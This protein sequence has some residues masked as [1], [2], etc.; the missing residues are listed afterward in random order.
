MQLE[1]LS[2]LYLNIT[3][4]ICYQ[5]NLGKVMLMLRALHNQDTRGS[6]W[7][8]LNQLNLVDV[9]ST[10]SFSGMLVCI[11]LYTGN[12]GRTFIIQFVVR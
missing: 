2:S 9:T 3:C 11:Q 5:K 1:T 6:H 10:S 12:T 8:E 7:R 4:V